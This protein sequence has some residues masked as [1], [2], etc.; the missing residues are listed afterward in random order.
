MY[1]V[2]FYIFCGFGSKNNPV[3]NNSFLNSP[4]GTYI[5]AVNGTFDREKYA[6]YTATIV[7]FDKGSPVLSSNETIQIS[8]TDV[9]D[10]APEFDKELNSTVAVDENYPN[11]T[12][13]LQVVAYDKD[14]SDEFGRVTYKIT[15]GDPGGIFTISSTDV[16]FYYY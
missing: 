5:L 10:N 13:I 7:A 11:E 15:A 12:A 6:T 1:F 8:I 9:N 16:S 4:S 2:A 3:M 14:M